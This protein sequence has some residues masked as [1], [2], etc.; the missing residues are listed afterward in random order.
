MGLSVG[1]EDGDRGDQLGGDDQ[2][3]RS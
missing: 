2:G 3:Q 1:D